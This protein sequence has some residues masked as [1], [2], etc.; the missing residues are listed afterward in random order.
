MPP[1]VE[2]VLIARR[3]VVRDRVVQLDQAAE[4]VPQS[5]EVGSPGP[6]DSRNLEGRRN[7]RRTSRARMTPWNVTTPNRTSNS[8]P[9]F[10]MHIRGSYHIRNQTD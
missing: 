7:S 2:H 3:A 9:Q 10:G 1:L 8:T 5:A 6:C 4:W